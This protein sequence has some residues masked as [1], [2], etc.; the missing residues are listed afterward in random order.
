VGEKGDG[1]V[2]TVKRKKLVMML[3]AS[4]EV[5]GL[6]EPVFNDQCASFSVFFFLSVSLSLSLSLSF[7][8]K[9]SSTLYGQEAKTS[10]KPSLIVLLWEDFLSR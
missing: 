10:F 7:V 5:I 4:A 1:K 3:D 8:K 9:V 6:F 2:I